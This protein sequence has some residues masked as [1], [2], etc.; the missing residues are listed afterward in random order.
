VAGRPRRGRA[1]SP[2]RRA[3]RTS[4]ATWCRPTASISARAVA[5]APPSGR[6]TRR[7]SALGST[8]DFSSGRAAGPCSA[9]TGMTP[10]C[11]TGAPSP[12]IPYA[13]AQ[14]V[15]NGC[16]RRACVRI[17]EGDARGDLGRGRV[18]TPHGRVSARHLVVCLD[19]FARG[20]GVSR[21]TWHAQTFVIASEPL[22]RRPA[23]QR[24]PRRSGAGLGYRPHLP[25][26]SA[27]RRRP[28]CS[29]W[30]GPSVK[31]TRRA[32]PTAARQDGWR[33]SPARLSPRWRDGA[34]REL[35]ARP[36]RR[37]P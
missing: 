9:P 23:G 16:W 1:H 3:A 29:S 20:S 14:G 7:A 2:Q 11:N 30:A 19:R 15:K 26:L 13:Y 4:R 21:D 32:R 33:G 34:L 22:D 25:V 18:E 37:H 36:H 10:A 27:H 5:G 28:G 31:P 24:L 35:L 6:S 17:F 12:S 8:A